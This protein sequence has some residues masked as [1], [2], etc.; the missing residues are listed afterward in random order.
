MCQLFIWTPLKSCKE[1]PSSSSWKGER[2]ERLSAGLYLLSCLL[3]SRLTDN[4]SV[5]SWVI[6][7]LRGGS[8][9][10]IRPHSVCYFTHVQGYAW[11]WHVGH[12]SWAFNLEKW[13]ACGWQMIVVAWVWET[14]EEIWGG[15]KVCAWYSLWHWGQTAQTWSWRKVIDTQV[16]Y[17]WP[18]D[19]G[20]RKV[21]LRMLSGMIKLKIKMRLL[22]DR[23]HYSTCIVFAFIFSIWLLSLTGGVMIN[24]EQLALFQNVLSIH[25]RLSHKLYWYKECIVCTLQIII[26]CTL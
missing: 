7:P 6:Q 26:T 19:W 14:E 2:N 22:I 24:V 21:Y 3:R 20:L 16:W 9:N 11:A 25:L 23:G 4:S 13:W 10:Q 12:K 18:L 15:C 1:E 5:L 8:G 17:I